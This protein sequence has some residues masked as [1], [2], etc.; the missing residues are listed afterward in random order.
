MKIR[1][2]AVAGG[3]LGLAALGTI[4]ALAVAPTSSCTTTAPTAGGTQTG[5]PD[6]STV[7]ANGSASGGDAG[8]T[9]TSGY[10]YASGSPTS[11]G[12]VQGAYTAATPTGQAGPNG[13]LNVGNAPSACLSGGGQGV[14]AP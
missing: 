11:G 4:P 9:G 10:L 8:I 7:W 5:L 12:S 13:Y 6:G 14:T 1:T 3:V 2:M